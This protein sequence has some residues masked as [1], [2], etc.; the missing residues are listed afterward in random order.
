M[1]TSDHLG[2]RDASILI[3]NECCDHTAHNTSLLCLSRILDILGDILEHGI[4]ATRELRHLVD[5]VEDLLGFVCGF[6]LQGNL[7]FLRV[8]FLYDETLRI[9]ANVRHLYPTAHVGFERQVTVKVGYRAFLGACELSHG[10]DNRATVVL[11]RHVNLDLH[12]LIAYAKGYN[13]NATLSQHLF[14]NLHHFDLG[15]FGHDVA[16]VILFDHCCDETHR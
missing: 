13:L 1:N 6:L 5:D 10:A 14:G 2:V 7:I 8:V 15:G 11:G 4:T 9:V 12:H 16:I 3:Y